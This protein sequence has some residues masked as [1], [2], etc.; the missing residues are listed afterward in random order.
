[1]PLSTSAGAGP[2]TIPE[3]AKWDES[4]DLQQVWNYLA[5]YKPIDN[6]NYIEWQYATAF[7]RLLSRERRRSERLLVAGEYAVSVLDDSVPCECTSDARGY[8]PCRKH[9]AKSNW[10]VAKAGGADVT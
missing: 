1:M 8:Y 3:P 4:L 2:T 5:S 10:E 9:R 6:V 7:L